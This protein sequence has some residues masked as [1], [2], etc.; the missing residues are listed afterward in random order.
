MKYDIQIFSYNM[1]NVSKNNSLYINRMEI[2]KE[3]LK[4]EYQ[5]ASIAGIIVILFEI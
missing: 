1:E 4:T 5:T 2:Y 3:I